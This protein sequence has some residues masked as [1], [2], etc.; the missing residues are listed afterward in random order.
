MI[1]GHMGSRRSGSSTLTRTAPL[2]LLLFGLGCASGPQPAAPRATIAP[3]EERIDVSYRLEC[4]TVSGEQVCVMIGNPLLPLIPRYPILSLGAVKTSGSAGGSP[5]YFLRA[6]YIDLERWL[7]IPGGPSLEL[8]ID[9]EALE[10]GGEGSAGSRTR[11]E[12][13]KIF[14]VALYPVR[15]EL[16][17]R[18]ATAGA[19]SVRVRGDFSLEKRLAPA[20]RVYFHMFAKKNIGSPGK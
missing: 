12:K 7:H 9:G 18:I 10:L 3:D 15:P 16:I 20:N 2:A 19:V 17:S 4:D 14:E 5:Q 13:G 1:P 8:R 11:G 6:V